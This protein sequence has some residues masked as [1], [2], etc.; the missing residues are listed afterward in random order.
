[1]ERVE[2]ELPETQ[3]RDRQI[4]ERENAT[5]V[6]QTRAIQLI[7]EGKNNQQIADEIGVSRQTVS[8]WRN[9]DE[10]FQTALNEEIKASQDAKRAKFD[11]ILD[12]AYES[13]ISLLQSNDPQIR[14]KAAVE[15]L[16]REGHRTP[17][18]LW[19]DN[20]I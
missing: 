4:A 17:D 8:F 20:A 11:T 14:L 2:R 12:A 18:K 5:K 1:M 16:K 3:E 9:R 6:N 15:V 10:E 19:H 13:L 7:L